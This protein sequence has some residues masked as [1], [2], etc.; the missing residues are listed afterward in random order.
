SMGGVEITNPLVR[1]KLSQG[2]QPGSL[3]D[4]AA[5]GMPNGDSLAYIFML[6]NITVGGLP[7]SIP[8]TYENVHAAN[9]KS[10]YDGLTQ[11]RNLREISTSIDPVFRAKNDV[12]QFNMDFD[13]ADGLQLVSQTA[14]SRDR[15]YSMQDYNRFASNPIFSDSTRPDLLNKHGQPTDTVNYPGPTPGGIYCDPQLGCSD[16]LLS[17]DLSRSRIHQ[18]SQELRLQSDFDGPINFNVGA[19]YVDFKSQDDYY[20]FNNACTL[21]ADWFYAKRTDT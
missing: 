16:R 8:G 3:Y 4:D 12:V 19:N 2:C 7:T 17:A 5:Y 21:I 9:G 15:F 10:P 20:V 1:G 14:Y 18:W 13:V 6:Y 11:S